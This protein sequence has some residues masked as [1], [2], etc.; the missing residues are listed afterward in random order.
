MVDKL[1]A[2]GS[3]WAVEN[4]VPALRYFLLPIAFCPLPLKK[5]PPTFV[6][7][8]LYKNLKNHLSFSGI[9]ASCWV[10]DTGFAAITFRAT[11]AIHCATETYSRATLIFF[12]VTTCAGA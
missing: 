1:K 9:L 10:I 2:A 5:K 7:G 3:E 8:S 11:K 6:D 4:T 12:Q